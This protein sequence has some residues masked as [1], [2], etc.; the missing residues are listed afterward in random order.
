MIYSQYRAGFT[1]IELMVVV[2]IV[3]ILAAI[4][5]P[6]YQD[7]TVRAK[8]TEAVVASGPAKEILSEAFQSNGVSG[9]NAAALAYNASPASQRTSKYV[10]GVQVVGA[11]TPWP[12]EVAIAANVGNGMPTVL[13]GMTLILS[14]NVQGATP[15]ASSAGAMDWACASATDSTATARGLANRTRGTLPPRYAPSECR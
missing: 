8:I 4:A 2:A 9:M 11:A 5:L 12:I 7:Y 15:L 1:L 6:A 3:G 13:D 10:S 14:P